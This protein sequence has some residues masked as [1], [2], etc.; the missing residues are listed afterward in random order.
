M[1]AA[2]N[3]SLPAFEDGAAPGAAVATSAKDRKKAATVNAVKL[4]P[5]LL[6]ACIWGRQDDAHEVG[7]A[8]AAAIETSDPALAAR[9]TKRLGQQLRP[10]RLRA[11]PENLIDVREPRHGLAEV[12][13]DA[14]VLRDCKAIVDE[15]RRAAEL[16]KFKLAPR[17]KV[18]LHGPP[19][20]GKTMLAEG[21]ARELDIPFLAVRYAGLVESYLGQ[22]GKNM[23]QIFEYAE[24]SSCLVFMDEFD[25]V[26]IDRNDSRDV[27][28]IRRVTNQL[29]L[30][31]DRLPAS[32]VFVAATNAESLLDKAI[33]RRFDFVVE[34]AAPTPELK[35]RCASR[36]LAVDMTPGYDVSHLAAQIAHLDWPNLSALADRC[37]E[38]RRDLV[39]NQGRGQEW[40]V[41]SL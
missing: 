33:R 19:G 37:R 16:A 20:N 29:L 25:G 27:G 9:I 36:E 17:H 21:L 8:I 5:R 40:L 1:E 39:L 34:I 11:C 15:H 38:I 23:Q 13:L 2:T 3:L 18:L 22:T 7:A 14:D 24:T 10:R 30:Q 28:E 26:A 35:L 4:L 32:C 41:K 31:M 6:D 12:I